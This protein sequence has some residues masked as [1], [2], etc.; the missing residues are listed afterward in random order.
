MPCSNKQTPS[1]LPVELVGCILSFCPA[2]TIALYLQSEIKACHDHDDNRYLLKLLDAV[3]STTKQRFILFSKYLD[4]IPNYMPCLM[5]PYIKEYAA[6]MNEE[7]PSRT[8]LGTAQFVLNRLCVL[9]YFEAAR[10][11]FVENGG[12]HEWLVWCGAILLTD[13]ENGNE[14]TRQVHVA[15][16]S[17]CWYPGLVEKW[18]RDMENCDSFKH[19]LTNGRWHTRQPSTHVARVTA[20][21]QGGPSFVSEFYKCGTQGRR[22]DDDDGIGT[23]QDSI[24]TS[25][26]IVSSRSVAAIRTTRTFGNE[27]TFMMEMSSTCGRQDSVLGFWTDMAAL[28][29]M[30]SRDDFTRAIV[31]LQNQF[32]NY[33][34]RNTDWTVPEIAR[35]SK[36]SVNNEQ[37]DGKRS[38]G[39]SLF[40]RISHALRAR[41]NSNTNGT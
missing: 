20:T 22:D 6:A 28:D 39:N 19:G 32:S 23:N 34:Q 40:T 37:H 36:C 12:A 18:K 24:L 29:R 35:R 16:S 38:R 3:R 26:L 31:Q 9:D 4:R 8:M 14:V 27:Q 41:Q 15:I 5:S 11:G 30:A 10:T 1:P 17:P 33:V 25:L 13:Y 21:Q 7:C 2:E